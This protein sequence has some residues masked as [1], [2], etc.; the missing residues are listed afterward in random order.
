MGSNF[1]GPVSRHGPLS[2][3]MDE[4]WVENRLVFS[5]SF[6][7]LSS[8]VILQ[9]VGIVVALG[10]RHGFYSPLGT[11]NPNNTHSLAWIIKSLN[12]SVNPSPIILS[13]L[14]PFP[15][16][17]AAFTQLNEMTYF[18]IPF[19]AICTFPAS[20]DHIQIQGR[21]L[22]CLLHTGFN[23]SRLFWWGF[24]FCPET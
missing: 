4:C 14:S 7:F 19:V 3:G 10:F 20:H 8:L 13:L 6:H 21:R 16:P 22:H 11:H 2:A 5:I 18:T 17:S 23:V 12:S 9:A 24:C 1:L 15:N